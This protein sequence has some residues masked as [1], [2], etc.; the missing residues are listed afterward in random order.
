MICAVHRW[1]ILHHNISGITI[2]IT[3]AAMTN[4]LTSMLIDLHLAKAAGVGAWHQTVTMEFMAIQMFQRV[5]HIY[6]HDLESFFYVLLWI[7]AR[8]TWEREFLCSADDRPKRNILSKWYR[9]SYDDIADAKR[10]YM[11]IDRFEDILDGYP[12]AFD[13]VKPWCK[14][15]RGIVF[16]LLKNGPL[17]IG[18]PS[19]LP[20]RLY[21]P[22]IGAFDN[23]IAGMV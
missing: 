9:G 15:I 19:D 21:D 3:G 6:R 7:C 13:C 20:D 2:I 11:Q 12:L 4:G 23:T 22:I 10:C 8:R 16:P 1:G 18:T 14:A 17:F 5:A